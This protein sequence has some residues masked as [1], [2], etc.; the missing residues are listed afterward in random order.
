MNE[1]EKLIG[2][3][4]VLEKIAAGLV[5]FTLGVIQAFFWKSKADQDKRIDKNEASI[6]DAHDRITDQA[7][8]NNDKFARRD[9]MKSMEERLV[10][11]MQSGFNG[12]KEDI[13][14]IGRK[15]E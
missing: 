3:Y 2:E 4:P 1:L 11:A 13:R 5:I 15:S 7:S 9:D 8:M 10:N 12:I 6:G 14:T